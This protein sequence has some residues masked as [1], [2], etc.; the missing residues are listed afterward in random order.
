MKWPRG[1]G[2]WLWKPY[3][4]KKTLDRMPTGDILFYADSDIRFISSP[5]SLI[6]QIITAPEEVLCFN[7]LFP[8]KWYT[9]RDCFIKLNCDTPEYTESQQRCGGFNLWRK[10]E[11]SMEVLSSWLSYCQ[12]RQLMTD[13]PSKKSN[14]EEFREHRHDQSIFSLV[15][16]KNKIPCLNNPFGNGPPFMVDHKGGKAGIKTF[17]GEMLLSPRFFRRC[18]DFYKEHYGYSIYHMQMWRRKSQ[19]LDDGRQERPGA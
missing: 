9:K 14:Y 5:L 19:E 15:T 18:N 3:I 2:Y 16:K 12:D 4:I 7:S 10:G 17:L 11:Q 6:Q 1:D 13:L 8:E